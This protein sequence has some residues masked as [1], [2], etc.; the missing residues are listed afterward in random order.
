MKKFLF[1]F[2]I[3]VFTLF[4]SGKPTEK[5]YCGPTISIDNYSGYNCIQVDVINHTTGNVTNYYNPTFPIM[6]NDAGSE[7][8]VRFYFDQ[9]LKFAVL[10]YTENAGECQ[11]DNYWDASGSSTFSANC[12]TYVVFAVDGNQWR[13]A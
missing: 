4:F 9:V 2:L 13:C 5:I 6:H 1:P 10:K 3:A 7:I 12:H 8:E 11:A